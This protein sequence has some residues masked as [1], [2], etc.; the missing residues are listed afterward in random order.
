M[1]S[2]G[3]SPETQGGPSCGWLKRPWLATAWTVIA[4][5]GAYACMYGFRKP[6]AAGGYTGT[7]FG[8]SLKTW[9]VTAQVLGYASAKF[10][11]IKIISELTPNRRA[12]LFL[13]LIGVAELG[14]L[15]FAVSP[16]PYNDV[17]CMVINGFPLGLVFGLVLG[18]V[19]GK[20]LTEVFAAGLCA[21][22]I[23][24]DG[25][26][27]SVG[28]W[29][30]HRGVSERA[31][32][33]TAGLIFAPPLMLFIWMLTRV[34]PPTASD[35]AARSERCPMTGMERIQMLRHHHVGLLTIIAAYLLI[36]VLRSIRADFAP[37]IWAG[38]GLDSSVVSFTQP[39]IWVALGA[40][41][42]NGL[43]VLVKDNRRALITA[44]ALSIAGPLIGLAAL[45]CQ[46]HHLLP[47]FVFMVALG[48]GI[49]LPY[50]AVHTTIFERLIA[51]T[52]DRGNI[53]Y[54]IYLADA[55]GYLGYAVV[56]LLKSAFPSEPAFLP[57]FLGLSACVLLAALIALSLALA[58]YVRLRPPKPHQEIVRSKS[59]QAQ[60]A[61]GQ[62]TFSGSTSSPAPNTP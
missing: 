5:F 42:A 3:A 34:P 51:L 29:L 9:L 20:R 28:V 44:L 10:L 18:F 57:F 54:L 16:A 39:E 13:L 22:F 27:K 15:L 50:V 41:T 58:N 46:E 30:L 25:W 12:S 6:F 53:G 24:A 31:M 1:I 19:E 14:L 23:I 55:A 17:L 56:M 8:S 11:G 7:E 37:E 43:V 40:V 26:A 52:R 62:S 47:P 59:P 45:F 32:P 2:T 35:V 48:L 61:K 38:L 4:A 36:T 60:P 33:Y 21:S 49:Y